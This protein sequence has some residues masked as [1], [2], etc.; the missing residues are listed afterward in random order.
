MSLYKQMI[1][2]ELSN[3]KTFIK[4]IINNNKIECINNIIKE[5]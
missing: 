3:N 5:D 1:I 2:Y 4:I